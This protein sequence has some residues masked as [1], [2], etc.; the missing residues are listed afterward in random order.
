[1]SYQSKYTGSEIE[2]KLD[3]IGSVVPITSGGTEAADGA[4]GLANLF[5]A[6]T[7]VLSS[8]QYGSSLPL[9]V[10]DGTL[11]FKKSTGAIDDIDQ[12]L[13]S[14]L[15]LTIYPVGS[16]YVSTVSASPASLFGGTWTA[17]N[18]KF[19]LAGSST[20]TY[21]STGGTATETLTTAQLPS[22][23]HG[24]GSYKI[25]ADFYIRHGNTSGTATVAS[26]T[27]TTITEGAY[28]SSW[29]NGYYTATYSHKP[30]KV[31]ISA[32]ATGTS[33]STG[34]DSAHNNMPPYLSVYMWQRT[35]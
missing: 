8:H 9:D 10:S 4:T 35:A 23:T 5:A 25:A 30:D 33:G 12:N 13:L 1:M 34:S 20:Y 14:E 24:A 3:K 22:H 32:T 11:F 2:S 16:I 18:D 6:G 28:S 21:G 26:G 7:T 29:A 15:M 17:I 19:L 31:A 27:N